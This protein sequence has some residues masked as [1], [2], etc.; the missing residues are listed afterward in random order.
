MIPD[1]D[2]RRL[3]AR[4]AVAMVGVDGHVTSEELTA[5]EEIDRLGLGRLSPMARE[6]LSRAT[7]EPVDVRAV[8][9]ELAF[10]GVP[11]LRIVLTILAHVAASDAAPTPLEVGLFRTIAAGLGVPAEDAT[12]ILE[13]ETDGRRRP[14]TAATTQATRDR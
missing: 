13:T 10:L 2:V 3:I 1:N 11:T 14:G 7:A 9:E 4:L 8:C 5:L 6:E 12:R